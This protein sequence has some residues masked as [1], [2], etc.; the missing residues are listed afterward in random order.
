MMKLTS[1]S[2]QSAVYFLVCNTGSAI[3]LIPLMKKL[4]LFY[5]ANLLLTSP[6]LM[7]LKHLLKEFEVLYQSLCCVYVVCV[8]FETEVLFIRDF[9]MICSQQVNE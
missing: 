6:W 8:L 2:L 4:R 9:S 3:I 1:L 5:V 7:K